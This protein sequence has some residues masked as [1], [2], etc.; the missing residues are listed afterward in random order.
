MEDGSAK[1][2]FRAHYPQLETKL[3]VRG[4]YRAEIY[5][6]L[7]PTQAEIGERL[8]NFILSE[9][10]QTRD[11]VMVADLLNRSSTLPAVETFT[12]G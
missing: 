11:G 8:G 3:T 6:K 2:G 5:R 4:A 7:A 1:L 10:D 9:D 12:G